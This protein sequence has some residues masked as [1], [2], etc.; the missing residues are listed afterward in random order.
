M[1]RIAGFMSKRAEARSEGGRLLQN[2]LG[3]FQASVPTTTGQLPLP[4]GALGAWGWRAPAVASRGP[5]QLVLDGAVHNRAQLD[6]TAASD[7]D[8][9]LALYE[10][11]G[12]PETLTRLNGEFALALFDG[13]DGSLYLAR[14]RFGIKPLY[15]VADGERVAF[16]SQPRA[17][18][19]LPGVGRE[20]DR[21]FVA[22][23]AGCHYRT[24]DNE[25]TRSPYRQVAQLPAAHFLRW[26][27]GTSMRTRW[28]DLREQPEQNLSEPALAELCRETLLD[29]VRLRLRSGDGRA[30]TL[31]GGMDSSSVLACAVKLTGEK[32][33]AL[34]STYH[35]ATYDESADIRTI[36][37]ATVSQWHPVPADDPD[38]LSLVGRM[39][40][41]NDEPVA[42]A[43][44]L[45]HHVLCQ[46]ASQD[47]FRTLFG[48]LGGDELNAG[49]Y[50]YFFFH[51]ADLKAAGDEKALAHEV[52]KW[53]EYH[54]H[55]VFKKS[56]AVVERALRELVDLKQPGRCLP[57]RTRLARWRGAVN[58]EYHD[59]ASFE[60][61]M[62][63]PFRSYLKNRTYQDIYRE[64][65]PCCLRA[66]DRHSTAFGLDVSWPFFDHRLVELMFRVPG[67]LKI[68]DGVT[69][70]L[71]RQ[72]MTG[73]VPEVTRARIK[74]TGWNAPAHLWF[75]GPG[76]DLVLDL[77]SSQA[78][79]ERGIY[80]VARVR[81]LLD[82]HVEMVTSGRPADNHMMF[83][84]QL[85]NL[86]LWLRNL[87]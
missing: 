17:L 20:V 6:R 52:E 46:Q 80:D 25:P 49:E 60:P 31:S 39:V 85:L 23:F 51:F 38:L 18:L 15:Y 71:L 63:A 72:A 27:D 47:G 24:F 68:R 22:L 42:T 57:D 13:R 9:L 35:D 77:L 32:Q 56:P 53:V 2:M 41:A 36:L 86:E 4:A 12:L 34:S 21:R 58:R 10:A 84:W 48:G 62:D 19:D 3:S 45:A 50:E 74:K 55:P 30:F 16:A 82:E 43:T 54:D 29:A 69:K 81:A 11:H 79:R 64:T 14:D 59:L 44:W 76:R 78:F 8:L 75:C 66:A 28:F 87:G 5:L 26:R 61:V 33:H 65:A 7:A 83:L 1:S 67:R 37:D 73:I 70:H 40:A